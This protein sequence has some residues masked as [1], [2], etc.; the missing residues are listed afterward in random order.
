M[1]YVFQYESDDQR[2]GLI[3]EHQ[4]KTIIEE[5]NI[6][7]GNFLIFSD[8]PEEDTKKIVYVTVPEEEYGELKQDNTLLK[9]QSQANSD[10]ADF[11]EEVLAEI[12]LTITP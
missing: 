10:R 8:S 4:D 5:L 9:A 7:E 2:D 3:K 6:S 12:I 11:H 1:R